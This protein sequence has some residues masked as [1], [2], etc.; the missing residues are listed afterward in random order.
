MWGLCLLLLL[1]VSLQSKATW[2]NFVSTYFVLYW[3]SCPEMD[4]SC[5]K[6]ISCTDAVSAN[7]HEALLF[8]PEGCK[9]KEI[10]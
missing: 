7:L 10:P 4:N 2:K 6:S 3:V 8:Q 5:F 1:K 9:E